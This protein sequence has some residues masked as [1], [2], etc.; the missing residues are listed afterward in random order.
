MRSIK[1]LSLIIFIG[2]LASCGAENKSLASDTPPEL[3][4]FHIVDSYLT[5]SEFE[6]ATALKI[7]PYIDNGEFE[8]FWEVRP[9]TIYR[10]ELFINTRP[11]PEHAISIT[12]SWC[13]PGHNC[14]NFSYQ[15]CEYKSNLRLQCAAPE[16]SNIIRDV[17]ISPLFQSIPEELYLTLEVCDRELFYCEYQSRA[18]TFE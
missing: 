1:T 10:A 12:S 14:R 16:Q 5:N 11:N 13:G 7:S 3:E 18:V 6:P 15:Y 8:L 9:D 2:V 17:D 4:A